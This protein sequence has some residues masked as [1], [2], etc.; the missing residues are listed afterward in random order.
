MS[1]FRRIN[2]AKA[3]ADNARRETYLKDYLAD[4][5]RWLRGEER[6]KQ[7]AVALYPLLLVE[8]SHPTAFEVLFTCSD[9]AAA[10]A[11]Q[12]DA[13]GEEW[14][15]VVSLDLVVVVGASAS[16]E[17][18]ERLAADAEAGVRRI[19]AHSNGLV[20]LE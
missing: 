4:E 15:V 13:Q 18:I 14:T 1:C 16:P 17:R 19:R 11:G 8:Q 3:E 10:F 5:R 2:T 9:A 7:V 12:V 6:S 20:G